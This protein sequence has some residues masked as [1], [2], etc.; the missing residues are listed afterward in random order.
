MDL[1]NADRESFLLPLIIFSAFALPVSVIDVKTR[2]IPDALSVPCFL[3][4]FVAR[5]WHS[6]ETAL[7]FLAAALFAFAL[8]FCVALATGGLGF[9]DVKF[10]AVIGLVCGFPGALAALFTASVLGLALSPL[11]RGPDGSRL[12]IPF[13]PFLCAGTVTEQLLLSLFQIY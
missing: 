6:P 11:F 3:L 5:L 8:F 13:A 10:A 2:R 7:F 4:V 9:G 1:I 12:P